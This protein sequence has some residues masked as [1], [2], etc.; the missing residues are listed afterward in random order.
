[1]CKYVR[2]QPPYASVDVDGGYVYHMLMLSVN[3]MSYIY[4]YIYAYRYKRAAERG[5][6]EATKQLGSMY[7]SGN[8]CVPRDLNSALIYLLRL[9]A[10]CGADDNTAEGCADP[11]VNTHTHTRL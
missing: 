2:V 1:M 10:G 7:I 5:H 6:G 4:I 11:E 8:R 9:T 3:D